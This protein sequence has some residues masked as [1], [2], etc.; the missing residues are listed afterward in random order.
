MNNSRLIYFLFSAVCLLSSCAS[1][2]PDVN[3][4]KGVEVAFD[5]SDKTRAAT[6]TNLHEFAVCGD[7]K[8]ATNNTSGPLVVFNNT[9]V[10]N[11]NGKWSYGDIQYWFDQYEHSFVAVSPLSVLSPA[12]APQYLNSKLS[13]TYTTPTLIDYN[14]A[15]AND[16]MDIVVATHRRL[17]NSGDPNPTILFRFGHIM[18][19]INIAPAFHDTRLAEDD[20]IKFHKVEFSD[21]RKK[22][23]ID[24][25]PASMLSNN[26]TDDMTLDMTGQEDGNLTIVFTTP[27]KV[28]ND[29]KHV[30]LFADNDAII[31]LPQT[32]MADS[33]AEITFYYSINEDTAIKHV[34]LTLNN[35]KWESGKSYVYKFTIERL[36][37]RLDQ[38]E[39]NPWNDVEGSDIIVE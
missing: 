13:F 20:Y 39:I 15:N 36:G 30:S 29:A 35:Q 4:D 5:V 16:M 11:I 32:F 8:L 24:I 22:S 33:V 1:D 3:T 19:L 27:V 21:V 17:Y 37:V 25:M 18:S 7:M 6:T 10:E 2:T 28:A 12:N 14:P 26:Q 31:M 34:N 23:R 38:C 9:K